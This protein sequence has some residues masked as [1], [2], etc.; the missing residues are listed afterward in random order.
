MARHGK[1]GR[2]MTRDE[3]QKAYGKIVA[4]AWADEGFKQRLLTETTDVL[5][6]HG[7]TLPQG[8]E[9]KIV[10]ATETTIHLLLPLPPNPSKI[11]VDSVEVRQ[12]AWNHFF[13]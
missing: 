6:E 1:E 11:N 10:E 9:A 4:K 3:F 2:K 5:K 8:V 12:A 13:V 7:I